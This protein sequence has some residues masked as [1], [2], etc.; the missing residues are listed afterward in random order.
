M[1]TTVFT[2]SHY[3]V[4]RF[5]D[6]QCEAVVLKGGE[7][8]YVRRQLAKLLGMTPPELDNKQQVKGGQRN[9]KA[10]NHIIPDFHSASLYRNM[11]ESTP[12]GRLTRK[13]KRKS[14]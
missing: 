5:G 7:R 14:M 12:A 10:K 11:N 2:A 6:L 3:G 1:N 4:V 13:T 9:A 8:G